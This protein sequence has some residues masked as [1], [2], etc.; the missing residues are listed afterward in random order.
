MIINKEW[1][2]R[3]NACK[4]AQEWWAGHNETDALTVIEMLIKDEYLDWANWGV[5]RLLDDD[6]KRAYAIYAAEQVLE[7]FEAKYPE[8]DR[9]RKAIEAAKAYLKDKTPE[10]K[11]AAYAAAYAAYAAADAAHAAA[12]A[13]HAA[14]KKEMKL[15]ILKYGMKLMK[16][17]E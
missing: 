10:N 2:D 9:P 8:D 13:A 5:A 3:W 16:E 12:H 14:A 4:E 11:N 1:L 15:R 6:G 17:G 7:I